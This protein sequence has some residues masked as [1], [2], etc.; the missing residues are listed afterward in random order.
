MRRIRYCCAASLDGYIAGPNDEYDWIIHDP[1][2]DVAGLFNQFDTF[3]VGRKTFE[4]LKQNDDFKIDGKVLVVSTTLKQSDH[5]GVVIIN[6]NLEDVINNLRKEEGKDIWIFGGGIL[7]QSLL[8]AG[9]VDTVEIAI[10]PILLGGGIP[11]LPPPAT[12]TKLKLTGHESSKV[13]VVLLKYEV[14]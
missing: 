7:F 6:D 5:P 13:G 14:E 10:I 1:E 8:N 11:L 2:F 9:L 12:S 3:L 4:V